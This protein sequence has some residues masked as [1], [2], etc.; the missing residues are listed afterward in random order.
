MRTLR[1]KRKLGIFLLLFC[2][3]V[4]CQT[5]W[6][7]EGS[8][9]ITVTVPEQPAEEIEAAAD[10]KTL[11]EVPLP[12]GWEWKDGTIALKPGESV[13]GTA[14]YRDEDGTILVERQVVVTAPESGEKKK[15]PPLAGSDDTWNG[16]GDT[17]LS[18]K[19]PEEVGR[20]EKVIV[21]GKELDPD[22]YTIT[23]D[24]PT[25]T[26][27]PEYLNTL[28]EGK[29]TI[30]LQGENGD[31][32]MTFTVKKDSGTEEPTEATKKPAGTETPKTTSAKTQTSGGSQSAGGKTGDE[33]N[34]ALW[35]S[36][37]LLS[38]SLFVVLNI[39]RQG[40]EKQR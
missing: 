21:D 29:H 2:L 28:S 27:K 16:E 9:T 39:R 35:A 18:I 30:L 25:V 10:A 13:T 24:P 26:L 32:E 19:V 1:G 3:V 5:V 31:V 12:E 22:D 36:V 40:K 34:L 11:G 4:S 14:V 17:G 37:M 8:A 20:I 23:G 38:L 15:Y 33:T 7:Q 6:A